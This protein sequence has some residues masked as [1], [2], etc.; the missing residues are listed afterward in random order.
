[1]YSDPPVLFLEVSPAKFTVNWDANDWTSG[2]ESYA[3][4]HFT[5]NGGINSDAA[6]YDDEED[7]DI[8]SESLAPYVGMEFDFVDG[9]QRLYNDY[10]FKMGFG[11]CIAA[12]KKHPKE[13]SCDT[14]EEGFLVCPRRE[15]RW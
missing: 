14:Y 13:S 6:M 3:Q 10:V 1:M 8:S 7:D 11:T 4:Q 9:T 2:E 15:A 5:T 12:S